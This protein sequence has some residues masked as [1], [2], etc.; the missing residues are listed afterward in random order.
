M[1]PSDNVRRLLNMGT[2][3]ENIHITM[4]ES[5]MDPTTSHLEHA[6][7]G[8]LMEIKAHRQGVQFA[9]SDSARSA[10]EYAL[11]EDEEHLSWLRDVY[12]A[13][14]S[15]AKFKATDKLFARPQMS[16]SEY[17][18]QMAAATA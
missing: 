11:N 2:A 13:Y 5:L 4:L 6:M 12:S 3:V 9:Q 15:S 17:I 1:I 18:S 14:G 10:H 16:A 8:E 7:I